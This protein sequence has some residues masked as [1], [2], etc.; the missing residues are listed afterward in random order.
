MPGAGGLF[1]LLAFQDLGKLVKLIH[2]HG[3]PV[4]FLCDD[5]VIFGAVHVTGAGN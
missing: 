3:C 4:L 5:K 2:Q 1:G